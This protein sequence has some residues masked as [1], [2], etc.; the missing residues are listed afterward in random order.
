MDLVTK[1][2]QVI[3]PEI[4]LFNEEYYLSVYRVDIAPFSSAERE[5][6]FTHLYAFESSDMEL[7]IDVSEE[8]QGVWYFQVLVPHV[9]TLPDV[10]RKRLERGKEELAAHF[11]RQPLV[12]EQTQLKG[13]AIYQYVK[14]YNPNL[15]IVG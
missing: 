8:H 13:D 10:A 14:R 6:L 12:A 1:T 4:V 9:L 5:A 2:Y 11:A 7:E 3:D 15:Q